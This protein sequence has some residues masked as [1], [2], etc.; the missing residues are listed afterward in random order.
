MFH[1]GFDNGNQSP[2]A[3]RKRGRE[4]FDKSPFGANSSIAG[5]PRPKKLRRKST[6]CTFFDHGE[7]KC[8][9]C[10]GK[11]V[12]KTNEDDQT[13]HDCPY[14]RFQYRP[15]PA[16]PPPVKVKIEG[17]RVEQAPPVEEPAKMYALL[18]GHFLREI[19]LKF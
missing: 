18:P 12:Y 5:T 1:G 16:K 8:P 7:A 4:E 10:D 3:G 6:D 14:C 19:L 11:E 15:E 17:Q 9:V 2:M 13:E